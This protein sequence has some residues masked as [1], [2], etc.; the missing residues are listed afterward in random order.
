[1]RYRIGQ[2]ADILEAQVVGEG[3]LTIMTAVFGL[4][5][6]T[7][8]VYAGIRARQRWLI[9]WGGGLVFASLLYLGSLFVI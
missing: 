8:F 3:G 5:T 1:M 2:E 7:L 6:G 9:F 4:V